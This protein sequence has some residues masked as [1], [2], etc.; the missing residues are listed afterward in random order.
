MILYIV[1]YFFKHI[2]KY[3]RKFTLYADSISI[4]RDMNN[5][6]RAPFSLCDAFVPSY[7]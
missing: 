1:I 3:S 4:S 7:S 5:G 6:K 2:Y